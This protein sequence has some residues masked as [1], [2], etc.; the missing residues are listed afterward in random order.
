MKEIYENLNNL[1]GKIQYANHSWKIC[2]N[3]KVISMLLGMQSGIPN[4]ADFYVI[5]TAEPKVNITYKKICQKEVLMCLAQ[6][7]S[8]KHLLLTV[9]KLFC[10]LFTLN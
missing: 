1:M 10:R 9:V 6:K 4:I 8:V 7:M 3:L 5:G 2:A